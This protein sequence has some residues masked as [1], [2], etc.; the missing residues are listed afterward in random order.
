MCT[1]I[2]EKSAK[3]LFFSSNFLLKAI[4]FTFNKQLLPFQSIFKYK[5]QL[6]HDFDEFFVLHLTFSISDDPNVH[7]TLTANAGAIFSFSYKTL[8]S[9][10]RL[11]LFLKLLTRV[12]FN[13]H[14]RKN[15]QIAHNLT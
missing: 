4:C 3:N 12:L 11:Q 10:H 7:E 9:F 14:S 13:I 5:K 15:E 1:G 8:L 2:C 6:K